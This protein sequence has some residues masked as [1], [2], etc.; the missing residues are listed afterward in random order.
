MTSHFIFSLCLFTLF[1]CLPLPTL[2]SHIH[3]GGVPVP[4]HAVGL[5]VLHTLLVWLHLATPSVLY[6][7]RNYKLGCI[8]RLSPRHQHSSP[9]KKGKKKQYKSPLKHSGQHFD[10]GYWLEFLKKRNTTWKKYAVGSKTTFHL[11]TGGFWAE[12]YE[13][14]WVWC[15]SSET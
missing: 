7:Y 2:S 12:G 10:R 6:F 14:C 15:F 4:C 5:C 13:P 9:C 11:P 1:L 8:P 3:L